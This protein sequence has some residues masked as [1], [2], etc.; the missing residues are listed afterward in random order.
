MQSL[1]RS[2]QFRMLTLIPGEA[3]LHSLHV[4]LA[5]TLREKCPYSELFR[6]LVSHIRTDYGEIL[7]ISPYSV[8]MREN[9]DKNNS[10]YKHFLHSVTL[11]HCLPLKPYTILFFREERVQFNSQIHLKGAEGSNHFHSRVN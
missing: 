6:S 7:R 3:H 9:T 4:T 1:V 10:E 11:S 2:S 8:R 5:I